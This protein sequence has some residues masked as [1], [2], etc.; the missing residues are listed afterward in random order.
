MGFDERD[1][2]CDS[3]DTDAEELGTPVWSR[4]IT[5]LLALSNFTPLKAIESNI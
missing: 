1:V 4:V 5:I 3:G 2:V